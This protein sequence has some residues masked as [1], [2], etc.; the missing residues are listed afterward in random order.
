MSYVGL[1]THLYLKGHVRSCWGHFSS[2]LHPWRSCHP[3]WCDS[4]CHFLC[5]SSALSSGKCWDVPHPSASPVRLHKTKSSSMI[6]SFHTHFNAFRSTIDRVC[7]VKNQHISQAPYGFLSSVDYPGHSF[8]RRMYYKSC[9][10]SILYFS[11]SCT[12]AM[13]SRRSSVNFLR[14]CGLGA[15]KLMRTLMSAPGR[16]EVRRTPLG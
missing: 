11:I 14:S 7:S 5:L 15:L 1:N 2:G 13:D 8:F 16:A 6:L 4:D 10:H 3:G 12:S 9:L